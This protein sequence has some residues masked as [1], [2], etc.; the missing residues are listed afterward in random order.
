MGH[1]APG[2]FQASRFH[3]LPSS[4][5]QISNLARGARDSLSDDTGLLQSGAMVSQV[6][7]QCQLQWIGRWATGPLEGQGRQGVSMFGPGGRGGSHGIGMT[8]LK[9]PLKSN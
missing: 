4:I 1:S 9:S 3:S 2:T 5:L 6:Q 7:C 8:C